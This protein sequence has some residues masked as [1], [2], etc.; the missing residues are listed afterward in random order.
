MGDAWCLLEQVVAEALR[1]HLGLQKRHV[2]PARSDHA[3]NDWLGCR[4]RKKTNLPKPSKT[5]QHYGFLSVLVGAANGFGPSHSPILQKKSPGPRLSALH[6]AL[7]PA[8]RPAHSQTHTARPRSA[9]LGCSRTP[10]PARSEVADGN[11][12][13]AMGELDGDGS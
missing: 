8:E 9:G 13:M 3:G 2:V 12:S 4:S 11:G 6:P 5:I 1:R 10:P 7:S